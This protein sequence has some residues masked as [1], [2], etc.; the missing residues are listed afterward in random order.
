MFKNKVKNHIEKFMKQSRRVTKLLTILFSAFLMAWLGSCTMPESF[1]FYQPITLNL[2]VPDGPP[3]YKAG[4]HA[5]CRTGL[6]NK[7]FVNSMVYQGKK[8]PDF[9][10]GV[11]QH[12]A[13]FQT[14][15]GQGFLACVL[16]AAQFTG[17][18]FRSFRRGPLE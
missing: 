9:G 17:D 2:A 8:G 12:D 3:E 15:W 11:Y 14:G 5:G 4:W 16:R 18:D 13:V 1:G 7:S 6:G 10:S